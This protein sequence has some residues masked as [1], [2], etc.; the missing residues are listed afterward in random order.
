MITVRKGAYDPQ[1]VHAAL[2]IEK[3]LLLK[4][5]LL[6]AGK[7]IAEHGL[8]ISQYTEEYVK[9]MIDDGGA[10]YL[11][12]YLQR[13]AGFLFLA[14]GLYLRKELEA[15][16]IVWPDDSAK[17]RYEPLIFSEGSFLIK[18]IGV[19]PEYHTKGVAQ[20]LIGRVA[21]D[22]AGRII[23]GY[24]ASSPIDNVRSKAFCKKSGFTT[25]GGAVFAD[26]RGIKDF[27]VDIVLKRC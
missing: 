25:V 10:A 19:L 22:K 16:D 9:N 14:P 13:P 2:E 8:L 6:A 23:T 21:E 15:A 12:Y 7:K 24:I 27:R 18:Q 11:A 1:A 17:E 5:E 20:A 3:S 26:Y 4:D